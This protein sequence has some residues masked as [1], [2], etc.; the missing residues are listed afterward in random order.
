M[1]SP[2]QGTGGGEDGGPRVSIMAPVMSAF[3]ATGPGKT[4]GVCADGGPPRLSRRRPSRVAVWHAHALLA[5]GTLFCLSPAERVSFSPGLPLCGS[6][7]VRSARAQEHS[8]ALTC[9]R[10]RSQPASP[11]ASSGPPVSGW[12]GTGTTHRGCKWHIQC[13]G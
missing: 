7:A 10:P 5:L 3:D 12:A 1:I 2:P 11:W 8:W 4:R 6:H 9:P 13:W